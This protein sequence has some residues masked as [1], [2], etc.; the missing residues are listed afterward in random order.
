[1]KSTNL[2]LIAF[3]MCILVASEVVRKP[4]TYIIIKGMYELLF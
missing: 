2:S 4:L 3:Y 1:V